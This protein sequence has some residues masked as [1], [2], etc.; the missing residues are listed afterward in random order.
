[1]E[2]GIHNS[3]GALVTNQTS[4]CAKYVMCIIPFN[5]SMLIIKAL[6]LVLTDRWEKLRHS[7]LG[8]S[9]G[10]GAGK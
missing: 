2:F 6:I 5:L 7:R 3:Y 4:H 1:M 9:P 8:L 10:H